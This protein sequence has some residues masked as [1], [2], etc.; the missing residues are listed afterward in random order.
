MK[1]CMNFLRTK[2]T[3]D[4]DLVQYDDREIFPRSAYYMPNSKVFFMY[5][6]QSQVEQCS[7][8]LAKNPNLIYQ[9]DDRGRSA[10]HLAVIMR[11]AVV[12]DMLLK[13][14]PKLDL[15]DSQ[16]FRPIDFVLSSNQG[17][18]LKEL[19]VHGAYPFAR[20]YSDRVT[21]T[22]VYPSLAFMLESAICLWVGGYFLGLGLRRRRKRYLA[23]LGRVL[24]GT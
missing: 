11:S 1:L 3:L 5:I 24:K 12:F 7:Q 13:H 15:E 14:K 19:L 21:R 8:M 6:R 10:L 9:V 17:Y 22:R 16:G 18:M 23:E 2:L 20:I 4:M